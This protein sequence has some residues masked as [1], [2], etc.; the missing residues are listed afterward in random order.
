MKA[1]RFPAA[2]IKVIKFITST[3]SFAAMK[4]AEIP[5]SCN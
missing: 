3:S 4:I 2:M 1:G 5:M